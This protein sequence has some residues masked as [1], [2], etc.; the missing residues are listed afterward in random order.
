MKNREYIDIEKKIKY[1]KNNFLKDTGE[2]IEQSLL[3]SLDFESS[4]MSVL[5]V[6]SREEVDILKINGMLKALYADLDIMYETLEEIISNKNDLCEKYES[7]ML[8]VDR[9]IKEAKDA[10]AV[11]SLISGRNIF[12]LKKNGSINYLNGYLNLCDIKCKY[13]KK[14]IFILSS[15]NK[16]IK[17]SCF[18]LNDDIRINNFLETKDY[19]INNEGIKYDSDIEIK[20]FEIAKDI[21]LSIN[22]DDFIA[23]FNGKNKI[24][25]NNMLNDINISE[26]NVVKFNEESKVTINSSLKNNIKLEIVYNGDKRITSNVSV[27]D[28][29][30][31][32]GYECKYPEDRITVD[33]PKDTIIK[34]ICVFDNVFSNRSKKIYISNTE[35]KIKSCERLSICK[36]KDKE[37]NVKLKI[38]DFD[39]IESIDN[40]FIREV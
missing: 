16:E 31:G 10:I 30:S 40:I 4:I 36:I 35:I 23:A 12:S 29:C 39:N 21:D 5:N 6:S 1:I 22:E 27:E 9:K 25:V 33:I 28:L 32:N 20:D 18:I 14:L 38:P 19:Y 37:I 15:N 34:F 8:H 3:D 26:N 17:N 2:E 11:E 24:S 7:F 13:G